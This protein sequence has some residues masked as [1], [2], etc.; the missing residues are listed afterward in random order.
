MTGLFSHY[1]FLAVAIWLLAV[2]ASFAWNTVDNI[3]EQNAIALETARA[4]FGQIMATRRWNLMHGGVYVYTTEQTPPNPYLPKNK[5]AILDEKGKSLT[6][7]NPAY[8]TREIDAISQQ[9]GHCLLYTSPSPRDRTR[10]RM[11]SSA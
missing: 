7:V 5:Q 2:A 10:S 3:R 1:R 8:M 11:P 9:A 4:F 6:L